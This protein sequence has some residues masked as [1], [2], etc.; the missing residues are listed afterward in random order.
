MSETTS[1]YRLLLSLEKEP[2]FVFEKFVNCD[3]EEGFL[4][5]CVFSNSVVNKILRRS[6]K[7]FAIALILFMVV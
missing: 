1:T 7:I 3:V 6:Q 5:S 4:V 2:C